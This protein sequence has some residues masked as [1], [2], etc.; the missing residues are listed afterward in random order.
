MELNLKSSPVLYD[1]VLKLIRNFHLIL[2]IETMYRAVSANRN[3]KKR[4]DLACPWDKDYNSM[5][6]SVLHYVSSIWTSCDKED[7]GRFLK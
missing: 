6:R 3:I 5:I 7:L 1:W 2:I 4:Y